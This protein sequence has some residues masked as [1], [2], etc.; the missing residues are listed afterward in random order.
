[1]QE[2][3]ARTLVHLGTFRDDASFLTWAAAIGLHLATDWRRREERRRRL[4]PPSEL[5]A[6]EV[7]S[8]APV[9][10]A[11]LAE[12]RDEVRRARAALDRLPDPMRLAVTLRVVEERSYEDVAAR[13]GVD[14]PRARQWVCRGLRRL[15]TMLE[16]R[17]ERT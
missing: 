17:D 14:V 2:V 16:V 7:P 3:F 6:D 13:L 1:V 4:A 8:A 10:G 11:R 9:D 5:G 12:D 15:R